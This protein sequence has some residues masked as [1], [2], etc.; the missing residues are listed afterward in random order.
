MY[1]NVNKMRKLKNIK[2]L[3]VSVIFTIMVALG[4]YGVIKKYIIKGVRGNIFYIKTLNYTI[5]VVKESNGNVVTEHDNEIRNIVLNSL[6]V[7]IY[8]PSSILNKEL[9]FLSFDHR[10]LKDKKYA[11]DNKLNIN[12]FKISD[13]S[14]LKGEALVAEEIKLQD[15]KVEVDNPNLKKKLNKAKPE[16]LIY[17]SHTNES[18]GG[19]GQSNENDKNVCGVGDEIAKNLEEKYGI[20]VLHDKTIHDIMY[21]SSYSKSRQTLESYLKKYGDFKIIIDLH[22]DSGPPRSASL[23]KMNGENV[24]KIM[25]VVSKARPNINK[26]MPIVNELMNTSN[27]LYPGFCNDLWTYNHGIMHFN[28][29][30]S[31]SNVLIE[32]GTEKNTPQEAKASGKYIA[33][34]LAEYINKGR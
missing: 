1:T 32:V 23:V 14:I 19:D 25:F 3:I 10:N 28:Q 4:S 22:R 6:G 33:R 29:D 27:K 2:F 26:N 5:P 18:Y 7:N 31:A 34:I 16:V 20:A 13:S 21:S 12:P 8:N 17:H 30:K 9:P 24:A 15:R 11:D